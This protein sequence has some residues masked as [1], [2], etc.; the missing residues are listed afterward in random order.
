MTWF[1]NLKTGR[2]LAVGFGLCFALMIVNSVFVVSR[3]AAMN[4]ESNAVITHAVSSLSTLARM[5]AATRRYR[6]IE[7][8]HLAVATPAQYAQLENEMGDAA[9]EADAA[10]GDYAKSSNSQTDQANLQILRQQWQQVQSGSSQ[11]LALSRK[12]D[13]AGCLALLM[14]KSRIEF[15]ALSDQQTRMLA[16]NTADVKQSQADSREDC[17]QAVS[18]VLAMN[19]LAIMI[20]G[21]FAMFVTRYIVTTINQFSG[22]L[23]SL[24]G[25]CITNL[26]G[27]VQAL[28]QGDLSASITTGTER[29]P[30]V[31]KDEF[32][33]IAAE[34]NAVLQNM[35]LTIHSFRSSQTS[36]STLISSLQSA[37]GRVSSASGTLA[38]TASQVGAGSEEINASIRDVESASEQSARSATEVAQGCSMQAQSLSLGSERVKEL[39]LAAQSVARDAGSASKATERAGA[40]AEAGVLA[41]E[42][43]VAGMHRIKATVTESAR[44]IQTLGE[45]SAQIGAI[46]GTIEEIADQTNLLALNAAIEAA[47]AGDAGRGFAVVADE[48]RKL[49]ERSRGAT[50]EI[51]ELISRVQSHTDKAVAS[52]QAGTQETE[53]GAALAEEAGTALKQIQSVVGDVSAQVTSIYTAAEE[54]LASSQE[55]TVSI[56]EV[57]A[58]VEEA[59]ASAEE[60]SNSAEQVAAS[61]QAVARA[62]EQ[63]ATA[64][65]ELSSATGD[66]YMISQ[67]LDSAV[68]QFHVIAGSSADSVL[69]AA[70]PGLV[71]Q[72]AA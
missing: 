3:M 71:M 18:M 24:G 31:S 48:V 62:L 60:M 7:F 2:K 16:R 28:E 35:Q 68:G 58:V 44:V 55:V 12:G 57:A 4:T 51:G 40:V 46:V 39:S 70:Q 41:V 15:L 38:A 61:V 6:T 21:L 64:V 42:Q 19:I 5:I 45:A 53:N 52:M 9:S 54:M 49:A 14:G 33:S 30:V 36:L 43:T 8:Q 32:G 47:R 26:L 56:T 27:A 69:P 11:V 10:I 37:A 63:Q 72:K 17:R 66:L 1:Y 23:K 22:R 67:S 29:L 20:G 59:S 34:F 65:E 25:I 50:Q 13:K